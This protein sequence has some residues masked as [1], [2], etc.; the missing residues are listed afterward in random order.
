MIDYLYIS[1]KVPLCLDEANADG[2]TEGI[3][4][5]GDLTDLIAYLYIPPNPEPAACP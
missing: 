1:K 4:D 5:I 3:V 2:D